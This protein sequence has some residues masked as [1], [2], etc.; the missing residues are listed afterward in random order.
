MA[1]DP[2]LLQPDASGIRPAPQPRAG[3]D[4]F[5]AEHVRKAFK[6][7]DGTELLI[8]DDVN[9]RLR[10]GEILVLLG[11]SGSGKSTL[12]RMLAGLVP[13]S[14]GTLLHRGRPIVAPVAGLAMVFQSFALFP[15]LTVLQNVELGL[16]ALKVPP[17]ERRQ[18]ALAA[19]D[20]IGLD[21]FESAYPRELSGGMRQRVGFARALVINPDV[22][23][24]D[25]PFSALDVLTAET[26]RTDLLDLWIERKIP[27]RGILLVSHNIEEAALMADRIL[28]L[29]SN[30]GRVRAEIPV[31]LPHPRDRESQEFRDLVEHIYGIMTA[32]PAASVNVAQRGAIS[33]GHRLPHV[34]VNQ[35]A[36]LLEEL[37]A[38][39]QNTGNARISLPELA[40]DM[41]FSVDD[42]FPLI[43]T[44]EL[45]GFA[46]V[47]DGE[48]ELSPAGRLFVE[49][50]VQE[51]KPLFARHLT[52]RV[53][54]AAR[55]RAVL[56][57]RHN[58]RAPGARFRTELEDHF[59]EEEAEHVL[60]TAIDWGR[61][62][63]IYAYDDNAD[64][65]SLDNPGAEEAEGLAG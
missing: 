38:L 18:R 47:S 34:S 63:E 46:Q 41:H 61:Y 53:P 44:V 32:R 5:L 57:E 36:G 2:H 14:D 31:A 1:A 24:M 58:H 27:T 33:I 4:I 37:S 40:E 59:S 10:E 21:G 52:E 30:P 60:D 22:L 45:L 13:P 11:R 64:V 8:L 12:L 43:E 25:E 42:L 62:A 65:F 7:P 15:W 51:R 6:A 19:I 28:I 16:E 9:M 54:L 20:L 26:M 55:I 23:L 50:D 35:L 56:D 29:G 39:E 17:T 3:T 49:A 48:I